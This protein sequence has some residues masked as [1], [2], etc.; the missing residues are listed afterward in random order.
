MSINRLR[1][2]VILLAGTA[3]TA[4]AGAQNTNSPTGSISAAPAAGNQTYQSPAGTGANPTGTNVIGGQPATPSGTAYSNP[5]APLTTTTAGDPNTPVTSTVAQPDNTAPDSNTGRRGFSWGLL[6]LLGLLG[7][8]RGR[9]KDVRRDTYAS[10]TP[11]AR[12]NVGTGA[13]YE[14]RIVTPRAASGADSRG[15][16]DSRPEG[17]DP[18]IL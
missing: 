16:R 17:G 4:A 5:N 15:Y 12:T 18:T 6:G 2:A 7:L 8:A 14:E 3:I 10:T 1:L 11:G 13:V 9:S